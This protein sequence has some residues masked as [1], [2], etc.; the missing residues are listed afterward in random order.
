MY[1]VDKA[2]GKNQG[3]LWLRDMRAHVEN[4]PDGNKNNIDNT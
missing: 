1:I 2:Q 3:W 4:K